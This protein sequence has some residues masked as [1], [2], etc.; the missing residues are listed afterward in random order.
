MTQVITRRRYNHV[1]GCGC[2]TRMNYIP[3]YLIEHCPCSFLSWAT[4]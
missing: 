1:F 2:R 3:G 4:R